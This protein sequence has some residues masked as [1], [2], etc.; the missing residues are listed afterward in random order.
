MP[1][2]YIRFE[3]ILTYREN[4]ILYDEVKCIP[5]CNRVRKR[6]RSYRADMLAQ[7]FARVLLFCFT[8]ARA[9][10]VQIKSRV[11][12][13]RLSLFFFLSS[14]SLSLFSL[15]LPI[16]LCSKSRFAEHEVADS[17]NKCSPRRSN[18]GL[19]VPIMFPTGRRWFYS[20]I[21]R[22]RFYLLEFVAN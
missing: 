6:G 19:K 12:H 7:Y 11:S 3:K 21:F 5:T 22:S 14:F 16:C 13:R 8:R 18:G 10:D 2:N 15:S 17:A 20:L 9:R 4:D 1:G